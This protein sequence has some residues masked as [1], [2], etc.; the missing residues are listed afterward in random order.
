M[1]P[2]RRGEQRVSEMSASVA[3]ILSGRRSPV[4]SSL[5]HPQPSPLYKHTVQFYR[6]DAYLLEQLGLFIGPAIAAGGSII[7]IATKAHRDS[8][9]AHLRS[10]GTDFALAVAKNRFVLLDAEETLEK[11]MVNGQPDPSRFFRVL[12]ARMSRLAQTA[13]GPD[14]QIFAFGEMV[15]TLWARNQREAALRLERLWNQLAEKHQFHLLCAYPMHLFSQQQ[16]WESLLKICAE[17]SHVYAAERPTQGGPHQ[18]YLHS[19]LLLQQKVRALESEIQH[20]EKIHSTLRE[21]VAE[22]SDSLENATTGMHWITADGTILWAN[23]A[24]LA[25]TGHAH[26]EYSGHHISEHYADLSAI[27]DILLR[28]GRREELHGYETRLRCKDGSFRQVRIDTSAFSPNGEFAYT[29]CFIT[30]ITRH[31]LKLVDRLPAA[32]AERPISV[33]EDPLPDPEGELQQ[34]I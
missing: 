1:E 34:E 21:R 2:V 15:A 32:N 5:L 26:H 30:D 29:R 13:E 25:L 11:F 3:T 6:D 8:L 4:P 27:E 20:R 28:L 12:G 19:M 16:D 9:F 17:H 10:C 24:Q 18:D 31:K 33:T 7:L 22:L 23:K 14:P